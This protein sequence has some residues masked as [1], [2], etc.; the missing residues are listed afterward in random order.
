MCGCNQCNNCGCGGCGCGC[1]CGCDC[2]GCCGSLPGQ[3]FHDRQQAQKASGHPVHP[4]GSAGRGIP[5]A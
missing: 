2:G 4:G 3:S 1:G 5:G